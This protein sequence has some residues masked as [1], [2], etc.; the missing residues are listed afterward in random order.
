[1]T[2]ALPSPRPLCEGL[3]FEAARS[4]KRSYLPLPGT[5]T[6]AGD[7]PKRLRLR[8]FASSQDRE[9]VF[10]QAGDWKASNIIQDPGHVDG[11]RHFIPGT[12]WH[13]I[14]MAQLLWVRY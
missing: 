9:A 2:L 7:I 14:P 6:P 5:T 4:P 3:G 10:Q 1:M 13:R 12:V 8:R 11:F